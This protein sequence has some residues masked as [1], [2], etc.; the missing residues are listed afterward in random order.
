MF[1]VMAVRVEDGSGKEKRE[2]KMKNKPRDNGSEDQN[3]EDE[4]EDDVKGKKKIT[5]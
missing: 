4:W 1:S 3:R 2:S 5:S